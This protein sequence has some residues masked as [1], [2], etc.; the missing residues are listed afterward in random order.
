MAEDP[1]ALLQKADKALASASGG[2]S[3]FGGKEEKLQTAAD[4]YIQAANAFKMQKSER[5][6]GQTFEKAAQIQNG[7]LNE[8]DDAANTYVDAFKA[9]RKTS[10]EDAA[11]CVEMAIAQYCRKGNF[12]RAATFK[13]NVG[14][15]FEV[16]VGDL[17]KAMAAYE[18]AAGWY[19][20]DGA[21]VLSNKLWLK[22]AD[23]A[24]LDAD[25]YKA[26]EAYEKV[27]QASIN[28]NLMKYSVKD[29]FLKGGL[30]HLATKDMVSARRALEKYTEMDPTFPS[31]REYKLLAD[32]CESVEGN[33][34]EKFE[35]DLVAF[36][37]MTKLDKWKTTILLRIKEQI[38]EA[39]NEFA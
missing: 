17:K 26:I 19:E 2:F 37:R 36:D 32:I 38:E 30:C 23:I 22:V 3:F 10:P 28:N 8:P 34:R 20:G 1:R 16:E 5:E 11:R 9:Y 35:D 15:M 33:D 39:D 7:K 21:A 31:T 13:E 27:S 25:Y 14:E 24:A 18:A 29:Y 12:R 6:A 4:Y